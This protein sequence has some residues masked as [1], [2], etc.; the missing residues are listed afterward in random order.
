MIARYLS[1]VPKEGLKAQAPSQAR[2]SPALGALALPSTLSSRCLCS[3][4]S[5]TWRT[6]SCWTSS[7]S[8]RAWAGKTTYTACCTDSAVGSPGPGRL[9]PVRPG[10]PRLGD[11]PGLSSLRVEQEDT[12][13]PRPWGEC[14]P[15]YRFHFLKTETTILKWTLLTNF[16]KGHA[17][18]WIC[19][20]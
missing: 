20:S 16:I 2:G 8:S 3:P 1:S 9:P 4:G 10:T 13:C 7:P 19:F 5:M 12:L 11:P 17:F 6:R 14:G 15:T 18:Y